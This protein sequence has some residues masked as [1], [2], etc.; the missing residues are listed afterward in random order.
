VEASSLEQRALKIPQERVN[1]WEERSPFCCG[2]PLE[3]ENLQ[4]RCERG[5]WQEMHRKAVEREGKGNEEIQQLR[6]RII[7]LQQQLYGRKSEKGKQ[8]EQASAAKSAIGKPKR[9]R[10]HPKGMP[11]HARRSYDHLPVVEEVYE[12]SAE[13]RHCPRCGAAVVE[14]PGTED[15]ETLEIEVQAHR[16]RIRRRRYRPTCRCGKLPGI[17]TAPGPSRLVAK[18][19]LGTSVWTELLVE[20]YLYQRPIARLLESWKTH[21]VDLAPGTVGDGLKGLAAL[22]EPLRQAIQEKSR[23]ETWWHA[24]ET[25]WRVFQ[26]PEGKATH[27]WYLW[28]FV[29]PSTVLYVLAP[30]RSAQVVEEHLG[31]AKNGVLCVDRYSAYKKFAK[32]KP[33]VAL[34]FCWTHQRRDFL[35]VGGSWPDLEDWAMGWVQRIGRV[36]H[37]NHRRLSHP[38]D[39]EEFLQADGQLR[40][41]LDEMEQ[42]REQELQQPRMDSEC[43]AVLKSLKNH[44]E[45]L[46]VFVDHPEIPMD[47]SEAERRMRGP[48]LGRKNYYGSVSIWS[49]QFTATLFSLFQTLLKWHINPRAWLREYLNAC[50]HHGG[51][52]PQ[53]IRPFLPWEMTEEQR[54]RLS[55]PRVRG[56]PPG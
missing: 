37:G 15:S 51:R 25:T 35:K 31:Q 39:S 23:Q 52:P 11:G 36:F 40:T 21:G 17:I 55:V 32:D 33:G 42:L 49:G 9:G 12:L 50:A 1:G 8:G 5:Y 29:S 30:G 4:L 6:A 43:I 7:Y 28:V 18:S 44:W 10:G 46:K 47:N 22:F 20:K 45:G 26:I 27:R 14:F 38:R 19:R 34:A 54:K 3:R 13:Q 24:D 2:C 56:D 53:D 16:R 48:A 41:A